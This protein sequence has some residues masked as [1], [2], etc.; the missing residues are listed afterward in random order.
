MKKNLTLGFVA[1][2]CD[3]AL[4]RRFD[5]PLIIFVLTVFQVLQSSGFAGM[6]GVRGRAF[7]VLASVVGGLKT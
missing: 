4:Q 6:D 2:G 3:D 1:G 5:S 7:K